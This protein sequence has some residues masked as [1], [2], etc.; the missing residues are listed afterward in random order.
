MPPRL[1]LIG[2]DAADWKLINPLLARG[3]MP[4][5]RRL[6]DRGVRGDISTLHPVLSPLLW[7]SIATGKT[8]DKHGILNF[9]EPDPHTPGVR[10]SCSTSR[11]TKAL[12][13]ILSQSNK[14]THVVSWYASHPAEP[15]RGVCVANTFQEG[16][17]ATPTSPWP[18][19]AGSVHPPTEAARVG[20]WRLHPGEVSADEMRALVPGLGD[21][22]PGD[23]RARLLARILAQ[24]AS[25][26]NVATGLLASGSP[27][28]CAMVYYDTIDVAGHHFMPYYPPRMD[29]VPEADFERFRDVMPGVY[30]L[31]DL[32]L[33]T[34]VDLAGPDAT[35]LLVSDHGFHSDHLRPRVQHAL[36]DPLAAMD[37]SWHRPLG[38]LAIAGPGIKRGEVVHGANLLDIAPTALTI[39]GLPVGADMD[40]RVLVEAFEREPTIERVFSWDSIEGDA[41]QHPPGLRVDPF[42]AGDAMKQLADLGYIQAPTGDQQAQFDL[43]A[44]E[45]RFNLAIVYMSTRRVGLALPIFEELSRLA[46]NEPRYVLNLAQCYHNVGRF[47]DARAV[48]ARFLEAHPAHADAKLHLGAALF[49]EQRLDEAGAVLEAAER[50]SA[51]RPDLDNLLGTVYIF[52]HRYDDA[53]RLFAR[54]VATDPHEP[55][56]HHG[57]ALVALGRRQLEP[58]VEHCLRALELQHFYPDAHYTLG[59]ALTWMG[60]Y[61]HAIRSFQ[62]AVSMQPGMIDAHRYLASI[63]RLKG[64]RH[65]APKHRDIAERLIQDRSLG[66]PNLADTGRG[67]PLG[68]IEWDRQSDQSPAAHPPQ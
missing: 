49:A 52:L 62:I 47:A 22:A 21:L 16:V 34:L 59:V 66:L 29:H 38:V 40:G 24:C 23:P 50:E 58:G 51:G 55:R 12:W 41:G 42:E 27:W 32:M 54:V 48:L 63:Y 1:L 45:T 2:W 57:L 13:N 25:V 10:L 4:N 36:D 56:G 3:E 7:T 35:I 6:L 19:P 11:R 53:E 46:P 65:N 28:D 15:I 39:L 30:R 20:E 64:D 61:D 31:H 33:G 9:I 8:A 26:H 18:V 60:E 14:T 44:R 17:P 43:V 5:L 68:P 67:P 37:A